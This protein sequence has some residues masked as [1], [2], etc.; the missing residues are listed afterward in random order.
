MNVDRSAG[1]EGILA[2][3]AT[4]GK[5]LLTRHDIDWIGVG[6]GGPVD[7]S[8]GV[9]A[10]SFHVSGWDGIPLADWCRRELG[11]PASVGN[12]CDV[13]G[14]AEARLGAGAG[15][16]VVL[17]VTVGTGIGGGLVVDGEIY[18]PHRP[19]RSEMGHLRP[20]L[21][22]TGTD[23]ILESLASGLGIANQARERAIAN[24]K[25]AASALLN[26]AGVE[27]LDH[28]TSKALAT[29]ARAHD[30]IACDVFERATQA[31]GWAVAQAIT[32]MAVEVVVV[33][34]GV[35]LSG[36]DLFFEPLRR[37]TATYVFP[38]LAGTYR[39]VPAALGEEVVIHGAI[40][41]AAAASEA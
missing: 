29:A 3:I 13:S 41:L 4:A 24:G 31:L 26:A 6:F 14:L 37:E 30:P 19:A 35:S 32:L 15:H 23:D 22:A 33:G 12:D 40:A 21:N 27:S 17:Y 7:M 28:L 1:A 36:E 18:A 11:I 34:G 38:P 16:R 8:T 2:Q 9:I 39:I 5:D 25:P 10:R 20:G